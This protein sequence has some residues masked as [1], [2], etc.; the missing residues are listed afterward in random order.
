MF[1]RETFPVGQRTFSMPLVRSELYAG[2]VT[3]SAGTVTLPVPA[4]LPAG[5]A[6]Y[7]E[8]MVTGQ[9]YEIDEA[10]S[11]ATTLVLEGAR[12]FSLSRAY[13]RLH[14]TLSSLLPADELMPG[15]AETADRILSFDAVGNRFVSRHV[16]AEGWSQ[17][18]VLPRH[19]GL[20]VH[21]R[22]GEVTRLLTG[23]VAVR[24]ALSPAGQTR[25]MGSGSIVE[26]SPAGLGLTVGRSFRASTDP[27]QAARLRLWKPDEDAA[28]PASYE[29]LYLSPLGWL[30]QKDPAAQNQNQRKLLR[31][32]RAFF[33]VP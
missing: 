7:L 27:A 11:T 22:H 6:C 2:R 1:S 5:A 4:A 9:G 23:Q 13:L 19:M 25:L 26:E 10:A 16:T 33:L 14:Q 12:P 18:L 20:M 24:P 28:L 17:D 15:T 21:L 30:L 8:D 3:L 29:Q 31:P 32:F